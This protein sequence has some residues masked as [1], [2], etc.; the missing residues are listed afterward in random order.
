A[1]QIILIPDLQ[2]EYFPQ[3]FTK[4]ILENRRRNFPRLI[5]QCGAV[6][7]ISEH[8]ESTIRQRYNN[9]YKDIFVMLPASPVREISAEVSATFREQILGLKPY[10]YFPANLWPHKNH[11]RLLEAFSIFRSYDEFSAHNLILTGH[12]DPTQWERL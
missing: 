11:A 6:A 12:Q 1:R 5:T 9:R 3:F 10:F 4:S 7:T 8:A 2:H